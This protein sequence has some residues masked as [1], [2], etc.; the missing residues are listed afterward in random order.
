MIPSQ[1][2]LGLG[3]GK[4]DSDSR[5][6]RLSHFWWTSSVEKSV[7]FCSTNAGGQICGKTIAGERTSIGRKER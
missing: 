5:G 7:G 1:I 6:T 4:V 3:H 2:L